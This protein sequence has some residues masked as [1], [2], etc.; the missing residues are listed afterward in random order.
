LRIFPHAIAFLQKVYNLKLK[1][2]RQGGKT[3]LKCI[4][5]SILIIGLS[6][7]T[8]NDGFAQDHP[9]MQ[10]SQ[11]ELSRWV[12]LYENAPDA[13]GTTST[14][15][16]PYPLSYSQTYTQGNSF[17][18][19]NY[20]QYSPSERNQGSCENCWAWAGTAAMEI[21]LA[22][23]KNIKDRL[24]VQYINSNIPNHCCPGWINDLVDFYSGTSEAVPWA[25][26]NAEW[27]DGSCSCGNTIIPS[28]SIMM[29]PDYPIS[30][31][32]AEKVPTQGVG[33]ETAINNIKTVLNQGKAVWFCFFVPN[34]GVWSSF[35][36][37]WNSQPESAV[38]Q[39]DTACG[40]N[41]DNSGCGHVVLCVGYDDSD[42]NNRYWI[43]LNSWGTTSMRPN[44]LFRVNMDMNYDCQYPGFVRGYA[45]FFQTLNIVYGTTNPNQN[46]C[47][48]WTDKHE[49]N[50]GELV[51]FH[52]SVDHDIIGSV[53]VDTPDG[54]ATVYSGMISTGEHQAQGQ[55]WGSCG[56]RTVVLED[57]SGNPNAC[58][59][60]CTFN[61][62]GCG[63]PSNGYPRTNEYWDS[64]LASC[65]PGSVQVI[66][67]SPN[68]CVGCDGECVPEGGPYWSSTA[69]R[70]VLCSQGKWKSAN[71]A[72][73]SCS[74]STDRSTYNVNDWVTFNY[75]VDSDTEV[76]LTVY[77]P[78]GSIAAKYGPWS[79]SAGYHSLKRQ[80]IA[81]GQR[82]AVFETNGGCSSTCYFE[83]D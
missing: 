82:T 4:T 19:L 31:I 13:Q 25:N 83:V 76:T 75:Y 55:A 61:V 34:S 14:P 37:F 16:T 48:V 18:L 81:G 71:N 79:T 58:R 41:Y 54:K 57:S 21:K 17:N 32:Q 1:M 68:S 67:S 8:T 7:T 2:N 12:T 47:S 49:Y 56:T 53:T 22:H 60:Q 6:F 15:N 35:C 77:R 65:T 42:P 62:V 33:K 73:G 10:P 39:P 44:G 70:Y 28:S 5:L 40:S 78:D 72:G 74:I 45:F 43:M 36:S 52:Y 46:A 59:A 3:M 66:C 23:D 63:G 26:N 64:S 11:E 80:V 50:Y 38:W 20:L 30:F 51:T 69:N 24:S 9:F 29:S 27:Q